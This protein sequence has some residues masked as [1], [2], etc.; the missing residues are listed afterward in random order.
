MPIF[1]YFGKKYRCVFAQLE[2]FCYFC[3]TFIVLRKIAVCDT[4]SVKPQ[5]IT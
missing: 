4:R 5:L 1:A 2:L 3:T